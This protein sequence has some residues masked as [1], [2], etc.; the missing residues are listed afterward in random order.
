M[1]KFKQFTIKLGLVGELLFFLWSQK[2]WW[3]IPL[4]VLLGLFGLLLLFA[5][6]VPVSPFVYPLF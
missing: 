6:S 1:K 2:L 5:Q 3:L 4:V